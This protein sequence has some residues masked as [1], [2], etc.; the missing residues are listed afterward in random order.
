MTT[1]TTA[2]GSWKPPSLIESPYLRYG[3][4]ALGLAYLV[5]SIGTL[6][7]VWVRNDRGFPRAGVTSRQVRL[8][9]SENRP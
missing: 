5:W 4:L 6:E 2:P 1:R 8:L 3:I 9:S 7:I